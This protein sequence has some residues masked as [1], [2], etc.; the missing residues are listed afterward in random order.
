MNLCGRFLISRHPS[1]FSEVRQS[2]NFSIRKTK[3]PKGAGIGTDL[4]RAVIGSSQNSGFA[5]AR[6]ISGRRGEKVKRRNPASMRCSG[7]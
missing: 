4:T 7:A 2:M 3:I 6:G 5:S 1:Y